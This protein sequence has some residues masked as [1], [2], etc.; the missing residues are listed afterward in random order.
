MLDRQFMYM[1]VCTFVFQTHLIN[2]NE[3]YC[4]FASC[5]VWMRNLVSHFEGVT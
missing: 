3:T 4:N 5:A 1:L 2:F